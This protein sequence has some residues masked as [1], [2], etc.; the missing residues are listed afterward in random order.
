[1]AKSA[2][3]TFGQVDFSSSGLAWYLLLERIL[4]VKV[5]KLTRLLF[6]GTNAVPEVEAL[7]RRVLELLLPKTYILSECVFLN[8]EV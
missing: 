4:A 2:E 8:D 7:H 1:L 3:F 6:S 5:V